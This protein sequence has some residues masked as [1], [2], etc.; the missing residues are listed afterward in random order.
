M[1]IMCIAMID[2]IMQHY[3]KGHTSQ[4]EASPRSMQTEL[5]LSWKAVGFYTVATKPGI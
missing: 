4:T 1:D 3:R 5:R 2:P